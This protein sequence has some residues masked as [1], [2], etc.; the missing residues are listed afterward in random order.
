M[1]KTGIIARIFG[2]KL[3]QAGNAVT[4]AIINFDPET[5]TE[6]QLAELESQLRKMSLQLAEA[7]QNCQR[8][9]AEA[10]AAQKNFELQRAAA[11]KINEKMIATTEPDKKASLETSLGNLLDGL[12]ALQADVIREQAEADD[13]KALYDQLKEAVTLMANQ[14]KDARRVME[15]AARDVQRAVAKKKSAEAQAEAAKV[16]A[17]IREKGSK[18]NTVLDAMRNKADSLNR[19]AAAASTEASLLKP[20]TA[21]DENIEAALREVRGQAPKADLASRLAALKK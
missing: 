20:A 10:V 11:E 15:Q 2:K 9:M 16:M 17:G 13:A 12:E 1:S 18:V 21:G 4:T 14:L 19:E 5:A 8:E 6:A 7:E 3:E